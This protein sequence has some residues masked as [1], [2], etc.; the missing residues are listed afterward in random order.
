MYAKSFFKYIAVGVLFLIPIF[1]LIVADPYFFPFITGKAFFFRILVEVAFAVWTILAFLDAR[2]RPRLNGLTISVTIFAI[3]ALLADLLGVN[4]VRSLFSNF[5]RMEGWITIVHLWAM[6]IVSTSLFGYGEDGKRMW[7]RWFN[8][9]LIVAVF[10]AGYGF[11]QLFGWAAI[12]QGST[13]IDA[14]LGNS[15]YMAIYMLLHAFIAVYMTLVARAHKIQWAHILK[16]VYPILALVFAFM[17]F[18][19]QTRGTMLGLIGGTILALLVYAIFGE[20]ENRKSK[21]VSA[22][23]LGAVIILGIAFWINRDQAFIQNNPVLGRLATISWNESTNQ[24][25]QMIWPMALKGAMERPILGWGQENFNYIFNANYDPKMY[26]QEQ[27]FDRAHSVFLDWLVASGILGLIAY[28]ALYVLFL[29]AVWKSDLSVASKSVLTGLLAGYFIH[30][31]FVFDNLASYVTFFA[32]LGFASSLRESKH[33]KF[34]GFSPVRPDVVNYVVAP[35]TIILFVVVVYLFNVRPIRANLNLISALTSCS[36]QPTVQSFEKALGI[37]SAM[38]NQEIREQLLSCSIRVLSSDL[39]ANT[40]KEFYDLTVKQI[41]AQIASTPNDAR[42]YALAGSYYNGIG[43][44][45]RGLP[46]LEKGHEL[47]PAKQ[48][49]SFE[50]ATV[51]IN[52][53]KNAEAL[54]LMKKAYESEPSFYQAKAA[55]VTTLVLSGKETEARKEFANEP[56]LFMTEQLAQVFGSRKEYSKSLAIY[57]SLVKANSSDPNL[58]ARYAQAQLAAGMQGAAIETLKSIQKDFP[59]LKDQIDQAIKELQK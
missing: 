37:G 1:P 56:A 13:R 51:Y 27:W 46:I 23:I 34:F 17:V 58:R 54:E 50:L 32:A 8:M 59:D 15:S 6:F 14:S 10:V 12:H 5:E 45:E 52:V 20:K 11:W 47:S 2:Y 40:K 16:W 53:G 3:I 25:R 36:N 31:I 30:N 21:F 19:T 48:T 26:A 44:Y 24:A 43:D 18:M 41:D 42:I 38:A 39:P 35:I 22:G 9:S 4:P 29:R 57:A 28:L 7:H 55:Y 33:I 49:I